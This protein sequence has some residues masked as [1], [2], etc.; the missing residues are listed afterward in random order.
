MRAALVFLALPALAAAQ[1][2]PTPAPYARA[3]AT[4]ISLIATPGYERAAMERISGAGSGWTRDAAGNLVKR[5]GEGSPR[6]VIACGL[7][8]RGYAVSAITDDGYLRVHMNGNGR[9]A[10]L[11]DQFHE[12][13]RVIVQA[14][15]RVNPLRT[16]NISG[17][18]AVRSNHLWRRRVL[19]DTPVSIEELWVDVG[20]RS[21]AEAERMGIDVLDPVV[22]DWPEWVFADY[23]AGPSAGNRAGCAAVGAV[24][25]TNNRIEVGETIFILSSRKSF[26]WAGL[27]SALARL[28]HVDTLT[29]VDADIGPGSRVQ[30]V[31]APWPALG[32]LDIGT[33]NAIGIATK[34]DGT[35]TETVRE[36]DISALHEAVTRAA[37]LG[38]TVLPLFLP[39][40]WTAAP[41][42]MVRDSLSR[43][44]DL[45]GKLTDIYA[46]SG[47]EQPMRDAVQQAMP[48]WARDSAKVDTAGNVVLAMGPNR[49]T[50]VFVAHMDEIGFL[51]TRI[52][53]D[54]TVSLRQRGTFFPY[55]WEGQTA[56]LH[57]PDDKIPSRDGRLGC[58]AEREGP[59]RGVFIPRDSSAQREP[60]TVTAWFGM[61]SAALVQAGVR[62]GSP[63]TS[64][65][66]SARL[67][68][69]RLTARSVDDRAGV[70][71]LLL[72]LEEIEPAKLD[73]KV[74]FVWSVREEGGLEGAKALALELGPT[75]T[76]AHPI[77]TFVSS[78]SPLESR[79]FAYAPIGQG[80]VVRA[81]DNSSVTP[82]EEIDRAL[83][84]ARAAAIPLQYGVTNGG[85]DGSELARFGAPNVGV[86]WPLRYSHSPAEVID[87]RDLRS[88]TRIVVALAKAPTKS[89]TT[90]TAPARRPRP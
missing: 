82:P 10:A 49:D 72:A 57:R 83:K 76:R 18:F 34:Y 48:A 71:S 20:A 24:G 79:R 33:I 73:H 21:R 54:G 40:G 4:W 14:V 74:V 25:E 36:A 61:D 68:D 11:W 87:L 15:D 9:R 28:G 7:D 52:A 86:A 70:T 80:A 78:D 55:L 56:L 37:G 75:V 8:E 2:A 63:L 47:F 53:R 84:I 16:R 90:P 50:A 1:T 22:R 85:N 89:P 42:L 41:P 46:V 38:G 32:G 59:L 43:Y 51:V 66:C 26:S 27:T 31:R 65:K 35:L 39:H 30:Q 88:L 77:D 12:G 6:R 58:G 29:I 64:Y 45:I 67:G 17:V 69:L 5:V 3:V 13:Q 60:A 23:V 81:L 62:V 19:D 44:A